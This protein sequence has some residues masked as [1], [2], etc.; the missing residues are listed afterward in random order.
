[1]EYILQHGN[2]HDP[3]RIAVEQESYALLDSLGIEYDRID[4]EP[5]FTMEACEAVDGAMGITMCKNLFL[6]NRTGTAFYLLL[7]PGDKPFKTKELSA[8][9]GSSRLSFSDENHMRELLSLTPGSVTVLGLAYDTERR[10]QLLIDR[11]LLESEF[12][13]C[14]PCINTAS[15]RMR[16]ADVLEKLLPALRH[17]PQYVTLNRPESD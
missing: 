15:I 8:Q 1:M 12:F 16:T 17:E 6:Q 2:P 4:H 9:I 10:V 14:H 3:A 7:M 5:L 11:E 13:G